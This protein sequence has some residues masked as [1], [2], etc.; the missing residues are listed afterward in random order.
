MT[1]IPTNVANLSKEQLLA[2]VSKLAANQPE[3]KTITA[4]V[5]AK[6][7]DPKTGE[8][9]GTDG[10]ISLYGLGRFPI[11]LYAGQWERLAEYIKSGKLEAFM[12]TN[13]HLLSRKDD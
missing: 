3:P 4:K 13:A 11:T 2:L 12:T 6:K 8:M 1:A 7:P 9:K 5:T 10:A